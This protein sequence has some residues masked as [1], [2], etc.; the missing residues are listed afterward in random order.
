MDREIAPEVRQRRYV[1]RGLAAAIGLA[2]LVFFFAATVEWLRPSLDPDDLQIARV[3]RGRI[4]ATVEANGTVVPLVEQ[5]VSSP[6]EARVLR[7]GRRAGDRVQAGDELLTL[8]TSQS[9]LETARLSDALSQK[10]SAATELQIQ[11]DETVANLRAQI[12]QKKLDAQIV[13]YTADQR[14]KLRAEGLIAEQDALAAAAGAKKSD[15]ELRQLEEALARA[16]RSRDVQLAASRANVTMAQREREES[17]RQ[18]ELAMLRADRNGV[19]TS[20]INEV[21]ATV[22]RGDILARIADLSSYRVEATISDIHAARLAAGMRAVVTLDEAR[23]GGTIESVDPRI[24]NGVAKFFI[25]LDQPAHPRLRNNLRVD[26]AVV[27]GARS[28][29]LVVRRGALARTDTTHAFV[30]RGDAA[31][32]VNVRF[33]MAGVETIEIAEGLREGD[34]VVISDISE[35]EDVKEVRLKK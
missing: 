15:I 27:T 20:I 16:L 18:L 30:V 24:V 21:G 13:H 6:V 34:Q 11:L 2:A 19:L 32:R 9:Q 26:V 29:V 14:A 33:G 31:E 1:R 7:V 28:N 10:E 17:R 5:V 4:E 8:D 25:T 12:E 3:E 22:R 35:Y 23:I